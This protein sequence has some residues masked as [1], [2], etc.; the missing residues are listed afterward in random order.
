MDILTAKY[1][2]IE[3]ITKIRDNQ[4]LNKLIKLSDDVD[5]CG[6]ISQ[7]GHDSIEEGFQGLSGSRVYDHFKIKKLNK[8][9][10]VI[11]NQPDTFQATKRKNVRLSV[12]SSQSTINFNVLEDFVW[13]VA[14][15]DIRQ[16]RK[17]TKFKIQL[18]KKTV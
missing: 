14:L 12:L 18:E 2:L 7:A 9:I 13:I 5:Y 16:S 11:Q 17:N 6:E 4:L 3:W 8:E 10:S 1:H 15:F